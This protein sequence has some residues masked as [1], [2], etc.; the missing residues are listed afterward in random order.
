[1]EVLAPIHAAHVLV[2]ESG[3]GY[4]AA[5]A[6]QVVQKVTVLFSDVGQA[7][8]ALNNFTKS[9][10]TNIT[11]KSGLLARGWQR[12]APYDAIILAGASYTIPDTWQEQLT[13][14]GHVIGA[15]PD[16]DGIVRLY[17]YSRHF[18]HLSGRTVVD[19]DVPF[20]PGL[21]PPAKFKF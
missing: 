5:L 3:S 20:L 15:M 18:G 14:Q 13:Q 6:A 8:V 10:Y 2:I 11:A 12:N 17:H 1:L 9:G 21:S 4:L 7:K 16:A 19:M